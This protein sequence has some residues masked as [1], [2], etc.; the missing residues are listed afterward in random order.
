MIVKL[1]NSLIGH[2]MFLDI[3]LGSRRHTVDT[4]PVPVC[5]WQKKEYNG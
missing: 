5:T 3:K 4:L 2:S 1:N